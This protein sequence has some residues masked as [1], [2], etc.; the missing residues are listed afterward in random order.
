MPRRPSDPPSGFGRRGEEEVFA[1]WLFSVAR[2]GFVDPDDRPFERFVVRHPGAVAVVAVDEE[3]FATLVRQLRPAVWESVLEVPAG[4]RDVDG[5][6]PELTA[7]RELAEEA[8]LVAERME[9]LASVYNSPGYCD[10]RTVIYL[11]TGLAPCETA[12]HG[13]E[14]RWMTT[15]RVHL[16]DA[17]VMVADGRLVDQTTVLALLLAARALGREQR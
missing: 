8:G 10:Q 4:T 12:R 9:E 2:A 3:G 15:E 7:R 17:G 13:E 14:E 6:P 1:G 11:A 5:E 16:D